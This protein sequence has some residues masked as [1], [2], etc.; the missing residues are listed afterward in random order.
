MD[1]ICN[2]KAEAFSN[3]LQGAVEFENRFKAF[4]AEYEARSA[5]ANRIEQSLAQVNF[6]DTAQGA[7]LVKSMTDAIHGDV[8]AVSEVQGL[9]ELAVKNG[10]DA[11]GY[12]SVPED[13]SSN[14]RCTSDC[15]DGRQDAN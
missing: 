1:G 10:Y 2:I 15:D 9:P 14:V 13:P 7:N 12:G 3:D 4:K 11:Q 5:C 8:A 6:P